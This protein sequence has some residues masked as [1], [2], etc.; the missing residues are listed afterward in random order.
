MRVLVVEDEMIIA[1]DLESLVIDSGHEVC[2]LATTGDEAIALAKA[3]RPD[4]VLSDISLA[5]GTSGM[6]AAREITSKLDI[7]VIF[8]SAAIA[9]ISPADLEA[10]RPIA[11]ISKPID[12]ARVRAA[13]DRAEQAL[14]AR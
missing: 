12:P 2:G 8:I 13:L 5:R 4:V 1:L 14:R 7:G 11:L 9:S 3:E 10:V 6:I